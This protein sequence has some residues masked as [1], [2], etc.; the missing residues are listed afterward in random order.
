MERKIYFGGVE[1]KYKEETWVNFYKTANSDFI[2]I[3]ILWYNNVIPGSTFGW[4]F[5]HSLEKYLKCYFLKTGKKNTK[6]IKKFNHNLPVLWS[7]FKEDTSYYE[8]DNNLKPYLDNLISDLS[9]VKTN[10]RYDGIFDR[11][12]GRLL[13][14]FVLICNFIRFKIVGKTEYVNSFYGLDIIDFC[15]MNYEQTCIPY[16]EIVV[17]KMLHLILEHHFLISNMGFLDLQNEGLQIQELSTKENFIGCPL[18]YNDN[19]VDKSELIRFYR[20][21]EI[22]PENN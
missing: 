22:L 9:T 1:R 21:L 20:N 17:H 4:M 11:S 12:S 10:L 16:G 3:L 6:E 18:C 2:C 7:L 19:K 13:Y 8:F 5:S 15:P 14:Y